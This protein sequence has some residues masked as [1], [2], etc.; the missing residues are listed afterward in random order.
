MT[1]CG[2]TGIERSEPKPYGKDKKK[3]FEKNT[4]HSRVGEQENS[5]FIKDAHETMAQG[6]RAL[7]SH[8]DSPFCTLEGGLNFSEGKKW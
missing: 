5:Q 3:K 8:D 2:I 6:L 7:S 1:S 4:V